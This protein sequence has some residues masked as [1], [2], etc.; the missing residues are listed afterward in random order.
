MDF[1]VIGGGEFCG[2]VISLTNSGYIYSANGITNYID[3]NSCSTPTSFAGS[4]VVS[5]NTWYY[6]SVN[7]VNGQF[8]TKTATGDYA[9]KGGTVIENKTGALLNTKGSISL[10]VGDPYAGTSAYVIVGELKIK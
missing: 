9:E 2:F 7:V 1:I 4:T 8:T 3:L 10:R 6:T 5:N